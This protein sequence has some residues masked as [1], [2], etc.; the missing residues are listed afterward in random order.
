MLCD[1]DFAFAHPFV[2]ELL[3]VRRIAVCRE[4][5]LTTSHQLSAYPPP[6]INPP[7]FHVCMHACRR[8][9]PTPRCSS[10]F[11]GPPLYVV[12]VCMPAGDIHPPPSLLPYLLVPLLL[13]FMDACMRA[14]DIYGQWLDRFT[15]R[16]N[17]GDDVIS[18]MGWARFLIKM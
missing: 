7:Y 18:T 10:L 5:T 9:P 12:H 17:L 1:K 11:I 3:L 13:L 2:L 16:Q 6:S 15:A 8:H 4:H 14:G